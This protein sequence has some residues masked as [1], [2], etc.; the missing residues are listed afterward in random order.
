MSREL[1]SQQ[2]GKG[3]RVAYL[4]I[5][6][7]LILVV[8]KATAGILGNSYALV[9]DAIESA[10]DVLTSIIVLFGLRIS[11]KPADETHPYGHGKYEPLA[12][13]VVSIFLILAAVF[14][15]I[16]SVHQI[17]I[18]HVAPAAFTLYILVFTV[19]LKHF[20]SKY[21][22]SVANDIQSTSVKADAWHHLSDSL[23]SGMAFIGIS[24][25]LVLGEGYEAADDY[26]AL[27]SSLIIVF[28]ALLILKPA[29]LE[30]L[31]TAPDQSFVDKVREVAIKVKGVK[32]THKCYVRK[33]GF[34]YFVDLDILCDPELSI[35]E[36]HEIA[37]NVGEAIHKE[38]PFTTK[39]LVHVEPEDD[40]GR[41]S[42]DS[43]GEGGL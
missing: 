21:A 25:A 39:V 43:L 5:L 7:N 17:I 8:V 18:P 30:L 13:V 40:Y 32:G 35:R 19:V 4:G 10:S 31:D 9:A 12:G 42:R 23:T 34:D 37:H 6:A 33:L 2:V 15:A 24:L 26:A 11:L 27:L 14:I 38:L 41:R 29:L 16:E 3:V 1:I 20:L 36:G 22:L 28:N